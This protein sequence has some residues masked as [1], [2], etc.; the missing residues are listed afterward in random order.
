MSVVVS[1]AKAGKGRNEGLDDE[2]EFQPPEFRVFCKG[3]PEKIE[4]ISDPT[5]LPADFHMILDSYTEKGYRVIALATK[6][7]PA[8]KSYIKIKRMN[9][10]EVENDLEFLGLIVLENRIKKETKPVIKQLQNAKLRTIMVTGDHIQTAVSVAKECKM[11]PSKSQVIFVTAGEQP[12]EASEGKLAI[13]K[14]IKVLLSIAYKFDA[15]YNVSYN[16]YS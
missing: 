15:Q 12:E 6:L 4:T 16:F 5:T 11:I 14:D 8:N 2:S 13:S 10:S 1:Y 3:S 9:T 7:L